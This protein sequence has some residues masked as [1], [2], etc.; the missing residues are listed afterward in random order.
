MNSGRRK[1]ILRRALSDKT[2]FEAIEEAHE[3]VDFGDDA[4]IVRVLPVPVAMT[5]STRRCPRAMASTV[6]WTAMR[7]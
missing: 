3:L 5:R 2:R 1:R 7:W 4:E 6:R